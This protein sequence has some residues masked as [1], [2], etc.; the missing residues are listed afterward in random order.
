MLVFITGISTSG[1]ST[2]AKELPK[3]GYEAHDLEHNGISAWFNKETGTRDA[4]FGQ[5]PERTK[6]WMDAHEW[7]VSIDWVNNIS[8]K[9]A[10][11]TIFFCGGGANEKDIIAKCDKIIWLSTDEGTI[12]KR[13]SIPRD[14]TYGTKPHE[15]AAAIE[16]NSQ[17]EKE[18]EQM[19]AVMIDARQSLDSVIKDILFVTRS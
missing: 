14:H 9:A 12:K 2:M 1:K 10:N 16:G 3:R 7:R 8:K 18:Y 13:V 4:E 19:G 5:V 6:E 15:L 17:K 11:K